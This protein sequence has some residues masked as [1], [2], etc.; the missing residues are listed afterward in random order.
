M[1]T[2]TC[3]ICGHKTDRRLVVILQNGEHPHNGSTCY[4]HADVCFRCAEQLPKL[5]SPVELD[6]MIA[7]VKTL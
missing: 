4:T 6:D 7:K 3:D 5:N 1:T 2:I